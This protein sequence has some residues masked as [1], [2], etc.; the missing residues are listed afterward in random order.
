[1]ATR[2]LNITYCPYPSLGM[3]H[4]RFFNR[5]LILDLLLF[6]SAAL[7][8][9]ARKNKSD[10][11]IIRRSFYWVN[12]HSGQFHLLSVLCLE[13]IRQAGEQ[14][15]RVV[16]LGRTVNVNYR[17]FPCF[18]GLVFPL[19]HSYLTVPKG[20][21]FSIY[22]WNETILSRHFCLIIVSSML[23]L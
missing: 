17:K 6:L 12:I 21:V 9:D 2:S 19:M 14:S 8:E 22:Y 18:A 15:W 10:G 11:S 20:D 7:I 23:T 4:V 5:E 16:C 13:A 3:R 1:M